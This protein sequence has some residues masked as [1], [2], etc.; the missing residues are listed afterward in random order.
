VTRRRLAAAVASTGVLLAAWPALASP[1][2]DLDGMGP[3]RA[4]TAERD[5]MALLERAAQAGRALTYTGTQYV[6]SWREGSTESALVELN[7]DP[8]QG[9][10]VV[11]AQEPVASVTS[12]LDPR[13]LSLLG[14]AY[15][16]EVVG[17]GRCAGRQAAVIEARRDGVVAGRFWVDSTSGLLLRR[18]VFDSEGQRVRSSAFLDLTLSSQPPGAP[19]QVLTA[20]T[21]QERPAA[22]AVDRLRRQG[23]H[24]P[25]TLPHGYRLFE[26]RFDGVVLHLAYT[27]G[28]STLSLFAQTG[29][30]GTEPMDGFS[31]EEV[32]GHPVWVHRAAPERVVWGGGGRVWTLVTDAPDETVVAA[33]AAL[34]RD[35]APSTGLLAR[36][37]RGLSR[38]GSMANPFS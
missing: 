5:A 11:G 13:M 2:R 16:L 30:L 6:A 9:S 34:P 23:W 10:V 19:Q 22:A 8:L 31:A 3:S 20:V 15:E 36:L 25:E 14:Q 27:D 24:V 32:E 26:T 7:H 33:V 4:V 37:G 12:V 18:E 38:L 21:G 29:E 28:L 1:Q 35:P 17:P